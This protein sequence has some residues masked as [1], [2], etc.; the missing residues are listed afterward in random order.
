MPVQEFENVC[1]L[2]YVEANN[3]VV[4]GGKVTA[5]GNVESDANVTAGGYVESA[6]QVIAGG[7]VQAGTYLTAGSYVQA[8]TYVCSLGDICAA[9]TFYGDG[10]GL[11][12][13]SATDPSKLPLA[14]GTMSGPINMDGENITS[15][16]N[17]C[18]SIFYGAGSG[19][20]GVPSDQLTQNGATD[21]QVL[22]WYASGSCWRPQTV[23]DTT[24]LP[25][26]G[27][28]MSGV[29]NMGG[30]DIV[31]GA[32]VCATSFYGSGSGLTAL[33]TSQ[34]TADGASDGQVLTWY[35]SGGCWRPQTSAA[36][37]WVQCS[38]FACL[39]QNACV[40]GWLRTT[41]CINTV[42]LYSSGVVS[43]NSYSGDASGLS[44]LNPSAITS[45]GA[46]DGC[47][48]TWCASNNCWYPGAGGGG[49]GL[50]S[51]SGSCLYPTDT[52]CNVTTCNGASFFSDC[53]FC[54]CNS[55]TG[56]FYGGEG[57]FFCGV[58]FD[59]CGYGCDFCNFN[60]GFIYCGS[61]CNLFIGQCVT[62]SCD[63]CACC[64]L[65]SGCD[66][67]AGCSMLFGWGGSG[68][69]LTSY[70]CCLCYCEQSGGGQATLFSGFDI[71]YTT[72]CAIYG[73]TYIGC[74]SVPLCYIL[75]GDCCMQ[76]DCGA[77]YFG[78]GSGSYASATFE[79]CVCFN[80]QLIVGSGSYPGCDGT[81]NG[82]VF[83]NGLAVGWS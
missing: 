38:G 34:L 22:T 70:C 26:A 19:L 12:N 9:G 14:G 71:C 56:G 69:S 67:C 7:Y 31:N 29:I 47:V 55:S 4:A 58:C 49:G 25:L 17:A 30:N 23:N 75:S 16:G 53:A 81:C 48:L 6:N 79:G 3:N 42:A 76:F 36:G 33:P 10:S 8:T 40:D 62:A 1:S 72:P 77:V 73:T 27:G 54:A 82:I 45:G 15:I 28:T 74:S 21:G 60:N 64:A 80:C 57:Y 63:V 68:G 78:N 41:N 5:V 18:A 59:C 66:V 32:S 52:Y 83:C 51:A 61:Q 46:S 44:C 65:F 11:D 24:K 50:W 20:T 39:G 43:G 37:L 2:G 35:A 13:V